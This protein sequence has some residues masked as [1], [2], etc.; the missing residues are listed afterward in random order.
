MV[1]IWLTYSIVIMGS[2]TVIFDTYGN[3]VISCPTKKESVEYINEIE[4]GDNEMDKIRVIIYMCESEDSDLDS[5]LQNNLIKWSKLQGYEVVAI[6]SEYTGGTGI[7]KKGYSTCLEMI[8][9]CE[10]EGIVALSE[11]IISDETEVI[12]DF[13]TMIG[14]YGGFVR[15]VLE[16]KAG[17]Y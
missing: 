5:N 13:V 9:A 12:E 11:A 1:L 17:W 8:D 4:E 2:E 6:I 15:F 10:A 16:G 14:C 3:K 7:G